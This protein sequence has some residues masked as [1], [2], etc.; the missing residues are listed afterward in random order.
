MAWAR[1]DIAFYEKFTNRLMDNI[2]KET[3]Y[4]G[5]MTPAI[6]TR[7]VLNILLDPKQGSHALASYIEGRER[8]KE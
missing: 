6:M 1:V 5:K 2:S 3:N 4:T 7:C 8:S